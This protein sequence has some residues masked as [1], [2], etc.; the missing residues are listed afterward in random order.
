MEHCPNCGGELKI[1]AAIL[2]QPAFEKI[3]PHLGLQA[4]GTLA[5]ASP[6]PGQALQTA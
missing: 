4:R 3:P 2:E 6:S 1:F 5:R